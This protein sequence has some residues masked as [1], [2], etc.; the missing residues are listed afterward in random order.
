[1]ATSNELKVFKIPA[2]F[3]QIRFNFN[4]LIIDGKFNSDGKLN[5]PNATIY[6][7]RRDN[8]IYPT[9]LQCC[10]VNNTI[11][12][13]TLSITHR[14]CKTLGRND[15]KWAEFC[16]D[17]AESTPMIIVDHHVTKEEYKTN[18]INQSVHTV[19][20]QRSFVFNGKLIKKLT[21]NEKIEMTGQFIQNYKN[22]IDI[23]N[24]KL[25]ELIDDPTCDFNILGMT[26]ADLIHFFQS[27]L[28][29]FNGRISYSRGTCFGYKYNINIK[30]RMEL[31]NVY[32]ENIDNYINIKSSINY[33]QFDNSK[34]S[35]HDQLKKF[36]ILSKLS[37]SIF[38]TNGKL[39]DL[40]NKTVTQSQIEFYYLLKLNTHDN[41]MTTNYVRALPNS[42]QLENIKKMIKSNM[43][44]N[45]YDTI[46]FQDCLLIYK[47][48][49]TVNSFNLGVGFH[50]CWNKKGL[51]VKPL[52]KL[53][54][55]GS[56][57]YQATVLATQKRSDIKPTPVIVDGYI[58]KN[59]CFSN[60]RIHFSTFFA[61]LKLDKFNRSN[62]YTII[63][64]MNQIHNIGCQTCG[65][66]RK[67]FE[68]IC[69]KVR[70]LMKIK[71]NDDGNTDSMY[72]DHG[73]FVCD[74]VCAVI[75]AI[76]VIHGSFEFTKELF[77]N[78]TK[79]D[80]QMIG[81]L[82]QTQCISFIEH[83]VKLRLDS[84]TAR[85]ARDF[86]SQ[87]SEYILRCL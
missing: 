49:G 47:G 65:K 41:K 37:A 26:F 87:L 8:S 7:L 55:R 80:S 15:K 14:N 13:G 51:I 16:F 72:T 66:Q 78:D 4:R 73:T 67:V 28:R 34:Q 29:L 40:L 21:K 45:M 81:Y 35:S 11:E 59:G 74:I 54:N 24:A 58:V 75:E 84:I 36:K 61:Q 79:C 30:K 76:E 1:M 63:N 25:N 22:S 31:S 77:F 52:F 82:F 27:K 33:N 43:N 85:N 57:M 69:A 44:E 9:T 56:L 20:Y 5:D 23:C 60:C 64:Q 17:S 39:I 32:F 38:A 10:V 48:N 53:K 46:E 2:C 70:E 6:C 62:V 42:T 68:A 83:F 50:N 12:S 18:T 86:I 71:Q 3:S 19:I